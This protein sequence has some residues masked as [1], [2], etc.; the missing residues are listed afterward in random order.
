[1]EEADS[2]KERKKDFSTVKFIELFSKRPALYNIHEHPD[3]RSYDAQWIEL[4]AELFPNWSEFGEREKINKV[5][6][7]KNRYRNLRT[8]YVRELKKQLQ[9][10]EAT[11]TDNYRR[12]YIYFDLLD[13]LR[14]SVS[15][16][17]TSKKVINESKSASDKDGPYEK[18]GPSEIDGPY[19]IEVHSGDN[20]SDA[21]I[22]VVQIKTPQTS[23]ITKKRNS[24]SDACI[25]VVQNQTPQQPVTKKKKELSS[26]CKESA[27]GTSKL[28]ELS[29]VHLE[30]IDEDKSFLLSLVPMFRKMSDSQKINAKMEFLSIIAKILEMRR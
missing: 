6:N 20:D 15:E 10:V 8:C 3:R 11:E 14:P 16:Q 12:S 19:E 13:F 24:S 26:N 30:H 18:D 2:Y 21:D 28:D 5:R 17:L 9:R 27:A 1:M 4:A 22:E 29:H 23:S 7:L 25:G